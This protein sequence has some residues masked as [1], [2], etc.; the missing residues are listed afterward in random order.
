L[1]LPTDAVFAFDPFGVAVAAEPAHPSD[2]GVFPVEMIEDFG[3]RDDEELVVAEGEA[4]VDD[5]AVPDEE[6]LVVAEGEA[7]VD[8]A[9]VPDEEELVVAEGEAGADDA[10]AGQGV[11]LAL[12]CVPL[13]DVD[14]CWLG[15]DA[16]VVAAGVAAGTDALTCWVTAWA[17]VG[18]TD[19][20]GVGA[21]TVGTDAEGA[22]AVGTCAVGAR[23][24]VACSVII[25]STQPATMI[26]SSAQT[27]ALPPRS[28]LR[29][30]GGSNFASSGTVI[31]LP[32]QSALRDRELRS[33]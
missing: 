27:T 13:V 12:A 20:W 6:E 15:V 30:G 31:V 19:V 23:T 33:I 26:A 8:D 29:S 28:F 1:D 7:G 25:L 3:G 22:C 21:C 24:A 2:F 16:W 32:R 17:G 9:A 5:A 14:A 4:G 10:A 11:P 18:A